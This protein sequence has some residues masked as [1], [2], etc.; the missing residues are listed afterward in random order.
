MCFRISVLAVFLIGFFACSLQGADRGKAIYQKLCVECHGKNGE[1]SAKKDID[2]LVGRRSLDSLAG[3]IERTMPEDDE[4]ACVGP[5]AKAVAEYI[6]H[7]FYSPEAQQRNGGIQRKLSRLTARQYQNSVMDIFAVFRGNKWPPFPEK[8]GLNAVYIPKG[9]SGVNRSANYKGSVKRIDPL[10]AFDFG[11]QL[12]KLPDPSKFKREQFGI[13]WSGSIFAKHTGVYRFAIRTRN[14]AYLNINEPSEDRGK[15]IDGWVSTHNDVREETGEIY[16]VGGR[17]Y[18]IHLYFFKYKEKKALIELRWKPPHGIWETIPSRVL[19]PI[20]N[21]RAFIPKTTFPPDDR[22]LGYETGNTISR[23]WMDAVTHAGL[24]A[25]NHAEDFLNE[26]A[27]IQDSDSEEVRRR[28]AKNFAIAFV[29]VAFRRAAAGKT[30]PIVEGA[31][32]ETNKDLEKAIRLVVLRALTSPEFLYPDLS[33]AS[34]NSSWKTANSLALAMWDSIPGKHLRMAAGKGQLDTPQRIA[35]QAE[36]LLHD[37]RTRYKMN[38]FFEHWLE[39]EKADELVKDK[40]QYPE[41]NETV[42][43]DLRTSLELFLEETTWS[44]NSDYR[45][46]LLSDS[47]YTND[48]LSKL[49]G[50]EKGSSS[51][52]KV[53]FKDQHRRGIVTH[54]LLLATQAYHNNSSPIHR[55]VFVA[56]NIAGLPL[57]PPKEAAVF[58]DAKFSPHLTM[59]EKVAELTKSK[60]CMTCHATINPVGFS[61][62]HFDA[63]GRWRVRDGK[64][65]VNDDATL[66]LDSG[67]VIEFRGPADLAEFAVKSPDAHRAFI[68]HLFQY[69]TKRPIDVGGGPTEKE[70]YDS[71]QKSGFSIRELMVRIAVRPEK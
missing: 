37:G 55:G 27:K 25:A 59:R 24:E 44:G 71:F 48:R 34:A 42:L 53:A 40:K 50:S 17:S 45:R 13:V 68:R 51:F 31:F 19:S 46:L 47:L 60:A 6:Y 67:E 1:G 14:G 54:P 49:Y 21:R 10:V 61:L 33:V 26:F 3:R 58:D 18:P 23:A 11:D 63:I 22:S 70:L 65:P 9:S 28:K 8:N 4:K 2:P 41:F 15:L 56:K 62:E 39:L 64:K 20:E 30:N 32:S 57:K 43:A 12:P 29:D 16:L 7:A 5:D 36:K 66:K 69:M 35:R 52:K 38:G